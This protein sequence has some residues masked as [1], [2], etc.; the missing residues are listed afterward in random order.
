MGCGSGVGRP[1]EE[2]LP[3]GITK[4]EPPT[5]NTTL[6]GITQSSRRRGGSAWAGRAD[7][8]IGVSDLAAFTP[9]Q[10]EETLPQLTSTLIFSAARE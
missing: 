2:R 5:A 8:G 6:G 1:N 4:R 9:T 3:C 10:S 7:F